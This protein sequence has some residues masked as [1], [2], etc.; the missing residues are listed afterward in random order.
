[1]AQPPNIPTPSVNP[2]KVLPKKEF[3]V[4]DQSATSTKYT[5]IQIKEHLFT[6]KSEYQKLTIFDTWDY[7]RMLVL[8]DSIQTT[9]KDE[10]I[11]HETLIH[12][13]LLMAPNPKKVLV[14]GGGDGGSIEEMLK[15]KNLEQ[16]VQV[17]LDALVIDVAKKYLLGMNKGAFD[18][19]RV[20]LI[21]QDGRKYLE[22]T[23][24][25]FDCIVLD[26]TDPIGPS[27]ALYTTEFYKTVA[28][29]LTEGGIV[30]L[31]CTAWQLFPIITNV[32]YHTLKS[33]FPH[34]RILSA[35]IPSY[36]MEL[37]FV[38]ASVTTPVEKFDPK[39]FATNMQERIKNPDAL[40]WVDG[41]FLQ[42]AGSFIPKPL[43]L[44]LAEKVPR[45][46]TDANPVTFEEFYP[47][48][49]D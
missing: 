44:V 32:I 3:Y 42:T 39:Q 38:H 13:T 46:S 19:P 41:E 25:R 34:I 12:P 48:N 47:W 43:K 22:E 15:H 27:A 23:T 8:D 20:K 40:D 31:H 6:G 16:I 30:S 49:V 9:E 45:L 36:G 7:G 14:I 1:M 33:V 17:E 35:N 11:Y 28:S 18:D 37:A 4:E 29:R 5:L 10:C 26:L 2:K 21:I 24:E